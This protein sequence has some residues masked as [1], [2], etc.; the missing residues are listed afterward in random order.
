MD[1]TVV[2]TEEKLLTIVGH[3]IPSLV[4]SLDGLI[5]SVQFYTRH[6]CIM[7]LVATIA[8]SVHFVIYFIHSEHDNFQDDSWFASPWVTTIIWLSIFVYLPLAWMVMVWLT[9]N[10]IRRRYKCMRKA[11]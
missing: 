10:K 7:M 3:A 9:R 2:S 5:S 4:L 11:E 8:I 6:L 1:Q